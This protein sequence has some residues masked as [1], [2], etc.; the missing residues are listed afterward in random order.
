MESLSPSQSQPAPH[1]ETLHILHSELQKEYELPLTQMVNTQTGE[2]L[3]AFDYETALKMTQPAAPVESQPQRTLEEEAS[4]ERESVKLYSREHVM[5]PE[6]ARNRRLKAL[7]A[8]AAFGI[9]GTAPSMATAGGINTKPYE[10]QKTL[11]IQNAV[12]GVFASDAVLKRDQQGN[13]VLVKKTPQ[14]MQE[15]QRT[16]ALNLAPQIS[17]EVAQYARAIGIN[18][19]NRGLLF[20]IQNIDNPAEEISITKYHNPTQYTTLIRIEKAQGGGL[21][22]T[23]NF[24]KDNQPK[25]LLITV[26]TD[27][28]KKMGYTTIGG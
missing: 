6:D 3:P 26:R 21:L 19:I 15:T 23:N 4:L 25:T 27:I 24:V 8:A 2:K 22:I 12:I 7:V 10:Q 18:I 9:A 28:N 11:E 20:A 5:R 16:A 1:P 13:K 17:P 14:E